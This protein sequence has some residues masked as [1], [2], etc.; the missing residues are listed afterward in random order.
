MAIS[1]LS[2]Y[3]RCEEDRLRRKEEKEGSLDWNR[4]VNKEKYIVKLILN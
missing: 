1:V 4:I 3:M 2:K